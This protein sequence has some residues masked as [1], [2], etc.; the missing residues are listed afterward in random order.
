LQAGDADA[1]EQAIRFHV[2]ATRQHLQQSY[3][4]A[5]PAEIEGAL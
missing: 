5:G 4:E 2:Q 3:V 1:L